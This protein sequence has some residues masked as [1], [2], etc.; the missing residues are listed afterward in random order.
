MA[1]TL[2][3]YF[4]NLPPSGLQLA[5]EYLSLDL[6]TLQEHDLPVSDTVI[7]LLM[8]HTQKSEQEEPDPK[9]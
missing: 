5:E 9:A 8:I 2:E 4:N 7:G 6:E 1:L 3:E